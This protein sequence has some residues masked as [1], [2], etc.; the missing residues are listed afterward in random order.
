MKFF[1]A[2]RSPWYERNDVTPAVLAGGVRARIDDL[3][4]Q[5]IDV[6]EGKLIYDAAIHTQE[7]SPGVQ[8]A[9]WNTRFREV[10]ARLS[11][12][13]QCGIPVMIPKCHEMRAVRGENPE[14]HDRV[15]DALAHFIFHFNRK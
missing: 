5:R 8:Q 13:Q 3:K 14:L 7:I 1:N 15:A 10:P 11:F 2:C 6:I 12:L 4:S 9:A